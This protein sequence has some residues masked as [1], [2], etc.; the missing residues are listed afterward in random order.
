MNTSIRRLNLTLSFVPNFYLKQLLF[1]LVLLT[2]L[3]I[4]QKYSDAD[5]A[6]TIGSWNNTVTFPYRTENHA[7]I[8]FDG[9][10]YVFGG[11]GSSQGSI[12]YAHDDVS[13][14]RVNNDGTLNSWANTTHFNTGRYLHATSLDPNNRK[15]YIIGGWDTNQK[16]LDDVQYAG[17]LGNGNI[18]TW[19]TTTPFPR[20][21]YGHTAIVHNG[22]LYVMGG[23]TRSR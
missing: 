13:S 16:P 3:T 12:P 6:G 15:I 11:W 2:A 18:G 4:F 8:A 9:Y 10:I 17:I 1:F 20:K 22:Y 7:A 23:G 21:V 14:A 5:T 19:K